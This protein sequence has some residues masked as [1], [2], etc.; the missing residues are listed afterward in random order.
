MIDIGFVNLIL[1]RLDNTSGFRKSGNPYSS[2]L[3]MLSSLRHFAPIMSDSPRFSSFTKFFDP[4]NF[5]ADFFTNVFIK[6]FSNFGVNVF[7]NLAINFMPSLTILFFFNLFALSWFLQD[8]FPSLATDVFSAFGWDVTSNH[9]SN[10]GSLLP[11]LSPSNNSIIFKYLKYLS[12]AGHSLSPLFPPLG[13]S[14]ILFVLGWDVPLNHHLSLGLFPFFPSLSNS[15][16]N[17]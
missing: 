11:S 7:S 6:L 17:E 16:Y 1:I 3:G 9:F 4:S 8:D 12:S 14:T 10:A 5:M 15:T 2:L 13:D